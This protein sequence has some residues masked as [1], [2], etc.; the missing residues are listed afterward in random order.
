[1]I[2]YCPAARPQSGL[3]EAG[4]VFEAVAE[5]GITRFLALFQDTK[6]AYVGPVRSSRPYY[7]RWLLGFDATYAHA[8][9]SPQALQ[10]INTLNVKNLDHGANGSTFDRVSNRYAP[11][12]LYTSID[13]LLAAAASHGYTSSTYTP[14]VRKAEKKIETPAASAIDIALSSS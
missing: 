1:M 12:N 8:G 6:P 10:D 7:I 9:G 11:H 2:E 3:S 4:V 13:R 5:G 14:I